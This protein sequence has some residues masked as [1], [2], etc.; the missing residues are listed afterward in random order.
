MSPEVYIIL[1]ETWVGFRTEDQMTHSAGT[2]GMKLHCIVLYY[3]ILRW[4]QAFFRVRGCLGALLD[5]SVSSFR[6]GHAHFL[7]LPKLYRMI[8]EGVCQVFRFPGLGS[9]SFSD[10]AWLL[11]QVWLCCKRQSPRS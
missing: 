3:I 11:L 10:T 2:D 8:P 6:R 1:Y 9:R 5:L 4:D 7:Y